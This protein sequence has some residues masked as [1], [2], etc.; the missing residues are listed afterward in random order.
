MMAD[1]ARL[2]SEHLAMLRDG[3]GLSD[4]I[5]AER[6][7]YTESTF[8]GLRDLGFSEAQSLAPAL[9]IPLYDVAGNPAGFHIRPDQPRLKTDGKPVKYEAGRGRPPI[10]DVPLR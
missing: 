9:V 2:S 3:S 6:G 5:I 4:E 7:Y 8:K 10:I 1:L